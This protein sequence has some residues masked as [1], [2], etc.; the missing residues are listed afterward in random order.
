MQD[1]DQNTRTRQ[2]LAEHGETDD[3][4][5]LPELPVEQHLRYCDSRTMGVSTTIGVQGFV[6]A[7]QQRIFSILTRD[8]N[9]GGLDA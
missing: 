7:A 3:S 8:Y 5:G 1:V 2:L 4:Q 9:K 6:L